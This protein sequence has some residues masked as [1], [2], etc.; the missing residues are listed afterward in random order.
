MVWRGPVA[1]K[2]EHIEGMRAEC[3]KHCAAVDKARRLMHA[4]GHQALALACV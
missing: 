2:K 4:V 1:K 3:M